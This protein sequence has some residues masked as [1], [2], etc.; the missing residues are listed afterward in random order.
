[1]RRLARST[2]VA[3]ILALAACDGAVAPGSGSP[4]DS[5]PVTAQ[6]PTRQPSPSPT[7][8]PPDPSEDLAIASPYTL[9]R[10]YPLMAD[11][12]EA[13]IR[14]VFVSLRLPGTFVLGTRLA[15]FGDK[16]E[17]RALVVVALIPESSASSPDLLDD[18]ASRLSAGVGDVTKRS[19]LGTPVRIVTA[20]NESDV[21]LVVG[22]RLVMCVGTAKASE[23]AVA[24]AIIEANS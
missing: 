21:I 19:I 1:M 16:D 13:A 4:G 10:P 7:P 11:S 9:V 2:A 18:L 8:S 12:A 24:T 15:K 5:V 3:V 6:T 14:T 22:D 20:P 23:L 17:F